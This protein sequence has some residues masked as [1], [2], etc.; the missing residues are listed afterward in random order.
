MGL[1]MDPTTWDIPAWE[2]DF[3]RVLWWT[4]RVHDAW[5]SFLYSRP[6]HIQTSNHNVPLPT[7]AN[8]LTCTMY[9]STSASPQQQRTNATRAAPWFHNLCRLAIL[10]S[11]LQTQICTLMTAKEDR[12]DRVVEI[13]NE[14]E[15]L[16]KEVRTKQVEEGPGF[17]ECCLLSLRHLSLTSAV[18]FMTTLL[19]FRCMLRRIAIELSIGLG[20]P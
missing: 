7:L 2:K 6:S 19:G 20:A 11:R 9:V 4:L 8:I 13:E 5:S 18:S 16:L 10:V 17:R 12:L 15:M 1:H 14:V 3:R